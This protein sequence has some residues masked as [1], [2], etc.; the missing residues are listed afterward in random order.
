MMACMMAALCAASA[1]IST[2][3]FSLAREM[4][5]NFSDSLMPVPLAD[6]TVP[7]VA[8]ALRAAAITRSEQPS[9]RIT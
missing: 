2:T 3:S 6:S 5:R 9:L 7:P 4:P 1:R 8:P